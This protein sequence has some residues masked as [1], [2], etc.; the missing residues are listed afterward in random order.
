MSGALIR[1]PPLANVAATFSLSMK[2]GAVTGFGAAGVVAGAW[3]APVG[4]AC[5][6]AITA[7][8]QDGEQR[9]SVTSIASLLTTFRR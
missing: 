3:H 5:A 4:G 9:Q 7:V 8:E 6:F 1:L 2:T